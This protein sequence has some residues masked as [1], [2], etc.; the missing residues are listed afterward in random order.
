[1]CKQIVATL[2]RGS[3]PMLKR[4]KQLL[5]TPEKNDY[6]QFSFDQEELLRT[7]PDG[8]I[9][10]IHWHEVNA[11]LVMV[12]G[13]GPSYGE[14][15]WIIGGND[16]GCVVPFELDTDQSLFKAI[17]ALPRFDRQQFKAALEAKSDGHFTVWQRRPND[18]GF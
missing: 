15:F 16:G 6:G 11:I 2:A 8:K 10:H 3:D 9:E 7:Y 12:A 1:M 14:L 18:S 4:L 5:K 13:A 17:Q